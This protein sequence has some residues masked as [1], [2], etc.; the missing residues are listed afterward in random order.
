MKVQSVIYFSVASFFFLLIWTSCRKEQNNT[1][2]DIDHLYAPSPADDGSH[3]VK[4]LNSFEWWYF[5]ASFR[6]G[7]S[8]VSVWQY[9][10]IE[11]TPLI[12]IPYYMILFTVYDSVGNATFVPVV[13]QEKDVT[14]SNHSCDVKMRE[15]YVSGYYPVYRVHFRQGDFGCDLTF[16]SETQGFRSPPG[17]ITEFRKDPYWYLG[18]VVAQPRA[19]VTGTLVYKG[20][21]IRVEGNGYHDHNWGNV[22]LK[23]LYSFWYW[24]R[25]LMKNYTLV[26]SSGES[27]DVL[28]K[29]PLNLLIG[30]KGKKLIENS[31]EIIREE[32]DMRY[33]PASTI[34][35]PS[36]LKLT[37]SGKHISGVLDMHL[38]RILERYGNPL[39][40]SQYG[41]GYIRFLSTCNASLMIDGINIVE[42]DTVI[43]EL[44]IP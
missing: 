37:L 20:R 2:D 31:S 38:I 32:L 43:H 1:G 29:K 30:F 16:T 33:D 42:T 36:E 22:P 8:M 25:V 9:G 21:E 4:S 24:G 23:S 28:A 19:T 6:N 3:Q 7:Y 14:I 18:W 17:G 5:D 34:L 11:Y 10:N 35:Y 40:P 39:N 26:Y 15:N 12:G 27:S 44:M 13:F 41:H